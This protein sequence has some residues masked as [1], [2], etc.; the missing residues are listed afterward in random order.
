MRRFCVAMTLSLPIRR[1]E[2]VLPSDVMPHNF[3]FT[4]LQRDPGYGER[5]SYEY[6]GHLNA[7]L[8]LTTNE[9]LPSR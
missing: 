1:Y 2:H 6:G 9:G 5:A 3:S 8:C 7:Y 4:A